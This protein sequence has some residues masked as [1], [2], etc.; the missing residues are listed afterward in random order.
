M[1]GLGPKKPPSRKGTGTSHSMLSLPPCLCLHETS[2]RYVERCEC[3]PLHPLACLRGFIG[4]GHQ[5]ERRKTGK[6]REQG[7][8]SPSGVFCIGV[9]RSLYPRKGCVTASEL[10]SPRDKLLELLTKL[11]LGEREVHIVLL[12]QPHALFTKPHPTSLPELQTL[13][14]FLRSSNYRHPRIVCAL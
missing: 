14:K 3:D 13:P 10:K 4:H 6:T 7:E 12:E 8:G 9:G 2:I 1:V 5:K 11:I